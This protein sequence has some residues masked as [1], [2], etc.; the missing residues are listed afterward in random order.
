MKLKEFEAKYVL[1]FLHSAWKLDARPQWDLL[2]STVP[3]VTSSSFM[4]QTFSAGVVGEVLIQRNYFLFA[5]VG[6][7]TMDSSDW[8]DSQPLSTAYEWG[9]AA[10]CAWRDDGSCQS[11]R[12]SRLEH[13]NW[14][15]CVWAALFFFYWLLLRIAFICRTLNTK[16]SIHRTRDKPM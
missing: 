13:H 3:S 12:I 10:A 2:T 5:V 4:Q 14:F 1:I 7:W 11:G 15:Y 8:V 9:T 6:S 16:F